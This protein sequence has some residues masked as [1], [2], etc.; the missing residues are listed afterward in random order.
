MK[1]AP[2]IAEVREDIGSV[3]QPGISSDLVDVPKTHAVL[4]IALSL[5]KDILFP[6]TTT[7]QATLAQTASRPE[8]TGLVLRVL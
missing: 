2:W 4:I 1:S 7:L 5:Q 6:P 3:Q 8:R